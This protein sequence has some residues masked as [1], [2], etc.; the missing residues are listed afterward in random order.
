MKCPSAKQTHRSDNPVWAFQVATKK[1][2]LTHE[3]EGF[4]NPT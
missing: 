1:Q 4:V 2:L 3:M